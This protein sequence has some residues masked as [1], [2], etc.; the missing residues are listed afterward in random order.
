MPAEPRIPPRGAVPD[1]AD[2][3]HRGQTVLVT[4]HAVG[5]RE[6]RVGQPGD[7]RRAAD[8][9]H[10]DVGPHQPL[11]VGCADAE[12]AYA[13]GRRHPGHRGAEHELGAV[14]AVPVQEHP[15]ELVP[16]QPG[17]RVRLVAHQRHRAPQRERGR[18]QLGADQPGPDD[19]HGGTRSQQRPQPVGV[20]QGAQGQHVRPLHARQPPRRGAGGQHH[21][22]RSEH[23][24]VGHRESPARGVERG[25]HRAE[26]PVDR[27]VLRRS[28]QADVGDADSA[29]QIVLGERR[30]IVRSVR[31]RHRRRS[32]SR[33][34]RPGGRRAQHRDQ[35]DR[36]P[37]RAGRKT[38]STA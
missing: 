34:N 6:T 28:L 24:A 16:V 18:G 10:H 8:G 31:S 15:A 20:V 12:L 35:P 22:I 3:G 5:D 30:A 9:H 38:H 32:P 2:G 29:Q 33:R 7:V 17:Q 14:L 37:R 36:P 19:R 11:A 4:D 23:R 25:R 27:Q 1:R 21:R 26:P 13:V